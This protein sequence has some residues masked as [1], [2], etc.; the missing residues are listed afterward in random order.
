MLQKRR[1][2][3]ISGQTPDPPHFSLPLPLVSAAGFPRHHGVV[4]LSGVDF[5]PMMPGGCKLDYQEKHLLKLVLQ[6]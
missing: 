1:Q 4:Y 3:H 5:K 6:T 2:A